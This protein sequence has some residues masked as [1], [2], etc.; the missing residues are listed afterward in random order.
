MFTHN[1]KITKKVKIQIAK[2]ETKYNYD[3]HKDEATALPLQ[4]GSGNYLVKVLQH[5]EQNQYA[6]VDVIEFHAD[7]KKLHHLFVIQIKLHGMKK[8]MTS[9]PLL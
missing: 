7:I 8:V 6:I 9:F 5:M 3:L 2:G 4:M 1:L